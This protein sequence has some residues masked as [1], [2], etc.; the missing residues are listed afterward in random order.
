M[1]KNINIPILKISVVCALSSS[2][3]F[4]QTIDAGSL[5]QQQKQLEPTIPYSFDKKEKLKKK[6]PHSD[7][8]APTVFVKR[9]IFKNYQDV[10]TQEQLQKLLE[11][12][13]NRAHSFESLQL[14]TEKVTQ[15]LQES[16]F[17]FARAFLP[18]QDVTNGVITIEIV[19]GKLD[20]DENSSGW[21]FD[22][23]NDN[24]RTKKEVLE[25]IGQKNIQSGEIITKKKLERALLLINDL[26]GISATSNVKKGQK[27][28]SVKLDISV[29]EATMF[30]SS[31][32]ATNY[33]NKSTGKSQLNARVGL[34]SPTKNGDRADLFLTAS[35]GMKLLRAQY[36]VPLYS[37]GL[38][39]NFGA[40]AME[41]EVITDD[42]KKLELEG[43]SIS[44]NVGVSYPWVRSRSFNIYTHMNLYKKEIND[45]SFSGMLSQRDITSGDFVFQGNLLDNF[46]SGGRTQ[47]SM[48]YTTGNIKNKLDTQ[49]QYDTYGS[50]DVFNFDINRL[51]KVTQNL[52]IFMQFESQYTDQNLDSSE[53]FFLGGPKGVRA[54]PIGEAQG[55]K[56]WRSSL[57]LQYTPAFAKNSWGQAKFLLFAD[58]GY[59]QLRDDPKDIPPANISGKNSYQLSGMG[60]G[61]SLAQSSSY[62]LEATWAKQLGDNDGKSINNTNSDGENDSSQFWFFAIYWF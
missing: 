42:G 16:G 60:V 3:S 14:L 57:E 43:D 46:Y 17:M 47:F 34:N 19:P 22:W 23:F 51:Q 18:K 40:T 26:S 8:N 52:N 35:E 15:F 11:D 44:F 31:I 39:A 55:D 7:N 54:Y 4:G 20:G 10:A 28:G 56:G 45:N 58:T 36:T 1:Y 59:I 48:K 61:V 6:A 49:T 25:A 12:E 2:Y 62:S 41:Y 5:L 9:F 27:P 37:N 24:Q 21:D 30:Y 33:G 38:S 50:Y 13:T 53:R 32:W 29:D